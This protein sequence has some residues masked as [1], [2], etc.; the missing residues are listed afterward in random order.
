[1]DQHP[2]ITGVR[3]GADHGYV[4]DGDVAQ[5]HADVELFEDAGDN[6]WALQ[7]WACDAPH[8]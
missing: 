2:S 5:L 4:V 7:L 6:R 8:A 3:L 1:M